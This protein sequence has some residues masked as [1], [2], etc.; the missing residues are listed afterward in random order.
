MSEIT[1]LPITRALGAVLRRQLAP[2]GGIQL[3]I[4]KALAGGTSS[5]ANVEIEGVTYSLPRLAGAAFPTGAPVYV[6]VTDT[7]MLAIGYVQ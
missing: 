1:P 4:G 5:H 3:L 2:A 6:L 7:S